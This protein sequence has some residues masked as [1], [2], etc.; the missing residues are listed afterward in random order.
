MDDSLHKPSDIATTLNSE[1]LNR[2]KFHGN[3]TDVS[4]AVSLA[5]IMS[6]SRY[7][8]QIT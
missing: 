4:V 5:H 8:S 1:A 7:K 3:M 6:I 2:G